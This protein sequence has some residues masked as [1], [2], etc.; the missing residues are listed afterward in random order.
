MDF[1]THMANRLQQLGFTSSQAGNDVTVSCGEPA[2]QLKFSVS[3]EIEAEFAAYKAAR[4]KSFD[5]ADR[6]LT[7]NNSVEFVL[8]QLTTYQIFERPTIE[9][10]DAKGNTVTIGDASRAHCFAFIDCEQSKE[11][12]G[13]RLSR[14][15]EGVST[16][17]SRPIERLMPRPLTAKFQAKGRR[18]SP[19]LRDDALRAVKGVLFRNAI[20]GGD[21]YILW[22][23]R[24]S[25]LKGP[26]AEEREKRDRT[27]PQATYDDNVV[28][29]YMVAM[30]SPFASQSYLA[31]YHVLEYHF[32]KVAE[33]RLQTRLSTLLNNPYFRADP[34]GL[35]KV[36]ALV[37]GQEAS[38]DE[39]E[40]LRNV[41]DH[42][43]TE[44]NLVAF[45]QGI[46]TRVGEKI[47]S[48][49][50]E[51]FDENMHIGLQDHVIQNTAKLVKHIRN[52]IVH[53]SDRHKREIR[54]VP[55]SETDDLVRE[56]VPLVRFLA[57]QVIFGTTR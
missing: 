15:A 53:S 28:N 7:L 43:V 47:Y 31:F 20:D 36:I 38:K 54:H 34:S 21:C 11:L 6:S 45:I 44:E 52:A 4:S 26:L 30:S 57:E 5:I 48:K 55:L 14:Y 51:I 33:T 40:M 9:F 25:R 22:K 23:Q 27:I 13:R 42:Y 1:A 50:R 46:E 35:D 49:R 32:L 41:L 37:R 10:T 18:T 16:L 56:F 39:T 12:I 3:N 2:K 29:F 24:Q 8:V 19:T 17:R